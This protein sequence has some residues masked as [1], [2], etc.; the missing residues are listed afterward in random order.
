MQERLHSGEDRRSVFRIQPITVQVLLEAL[1][2]NCCF[3]FACSHHLPDEGGLL[4][5]TSPG[6]LQEDVRLLPR[7]PP[8]N[9]L[10]SRSLPRLPGASRLQTPTV[11]RRDNPGLRPRHDRSSALQEAERRGS[12]PSTSSTTLQAKSKSIQSGCS[13]LLLVGIK[14]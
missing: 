5:P 7:C 14:R 10:V 13:N 3:F 11:G 2:L 8:A 4:S 1:T 6:A 12:C 9:H